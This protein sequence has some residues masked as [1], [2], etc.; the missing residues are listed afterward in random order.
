MDEKTITYKK[1]NNISFIVNG[2]K[3]IHQKFI[4]TLNGRWNSRVK[5]FQPGWIVPIEKEND[6][7]IYIESLNIDNLNKNIKSRKSQNKYHR[8]ISVS[9]SDDDED[10]DNLSV[11]EDIK[12]IELKLDSDNEKKFDKKEVSKIETEVLNKKILE[13][14]QKFEKEKEAFEKRKSNEK[15]DIKKSRSN[16]KED[17]KKNR[18][19]EKQDIEKRKSNEKEAFEKRKL[20]EKEDIENPIP[21]YKSFNKKPID[22]KKINNY[23]SEEDRFS[24]SGKSESSEDSFPSPKTPKKRKKYYKDDT[25]NNNY[26]D[27]FSEMK[28]LQRQIYEMQIENKKLKSKNLK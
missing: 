18:S 24:S 12:H 5:D 16:E 1:Y 27:L 19:N 8:A 10:D 2:N 26:D 20:N 11:E 22:F 7:K 25:R 4:K 15:E 17:I 28:D 23:E 9:S 3:E 13:E 14:K 6:L 21:Y